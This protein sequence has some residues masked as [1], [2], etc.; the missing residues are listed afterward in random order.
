M[1]VSSLSS[2]NEM[3][4][5]KNELN[6]DFSSNPLIKETNFHSDKIGTLI[7]NGKSA[8]FNFSRKK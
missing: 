3:K 2:S 8:T 4:T 5:I 1:V 7:G 6:P